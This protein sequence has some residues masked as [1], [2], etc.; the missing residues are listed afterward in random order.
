MRQ[1]SLLPCRE[2]Q[3]KQKR[4]KLILLFFGIILANFLLIVW[5]NAS[6]SHQ[7]QKLN[8]HK[9][10]LA[11]QL[12]TMGLSIKK[13]Q[14]IKQ[15]YNRLQ[16]AKNSLSLNHDKI[17]RILALLN[18]LNRLATPPSFHVKT[19]SYKLS[20]LSIA[21]V[22]KSELIFIRL[23][24]KLEKKYGVKFKYHYKKDRKLLLEFTINIR[25]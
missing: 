24:K 11:D 1:I 5:F 7:L 10:Q 3:E 20:Y 15:Q 16:T 19:I 14:H 17:R 18:E 21:G 13:L 23:I 6:I 8:L 4:M 12:S 22:V 9:H 25:I 2:Q